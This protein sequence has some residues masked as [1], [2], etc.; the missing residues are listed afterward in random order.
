MLRT[1]T[2]KG[3]SAMA[4]HLLVV[5]T[6]PVTGREDEYNRWYSLTHLQEV[7]QIPGFVSAQRFRSADAQ[8]GDAG[9]F[10]YLALYELETDDLAAT[11]QALRDAV[12]GLQMSDALDSNLT[13]LAFTPITETVMG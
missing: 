9:D 11:L 13:A 7:V 1:L 5:N 8:L 2:A 3:A 10:R 12:P 6:N 4:R